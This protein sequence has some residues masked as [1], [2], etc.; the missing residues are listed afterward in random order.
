M[1]PVFIIVFIF[2]ASFAYAAVK[3][4]PWV[5]T[6]ARDLQRI[7]RLL[8]VKP[9]QTVYELGCGDGRVSTLLAKQTGAQVIGVELSLAQ[10]LAA[11]VRKYV[12]RTPNVHF[13]LRDVFAVDLSKADVVYLFL[14]P[15]A[16]ANLKPKFERELKPGAKVLT[17]VWPIEGWEPKTVDIQKGSENLYLYER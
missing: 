6:R 12:T 3:G 10:W 13:R 16:Y 1:F 9:G 11:T 4:A 17:Y 2:L 15:E 5:P 8:D 14:M 7:V